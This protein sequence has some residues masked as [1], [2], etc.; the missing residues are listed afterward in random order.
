VPTKIL[1]LF[2]LVPIILIVLVTELFQGSRVSHLRHLKRSVKITAN[3]FFYHF[4]GTTANVIINEVLKSLASTPRPHFFYTCNPDLTKINCSENG[5]YVEFNPEM[6]RSSNERYHN[7][8]ASPRKMYDSMKSFP[9]G[10]AQMAC[11]TATFIIIYIQ[12]RV[13]TTYSRLW[14]HWLQ[15]VV[16]CLAAFASLSRVTDHRHHPVDVFAG[17]VLGTATAIFTAVFVA[18]FPASLAS[19]G[20]GGEQ[21]EQQ[22]QQEQEV[23][24]TTDDKRDRYARQ[25]R[26]SKM[27]LLSS[28]TDFGFGS[29]EEGDKEL[30]EVNPA[31]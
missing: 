18:R 8:L 26:P 20:A 7:H 27:R 24:D 5:G 25:K 4:I 11:F 28:M 9:S 10:H 23:A 17:A 21:Q 30:A 6:C 13:G 31:C 29:V 1:I 14:K 12:L 2:I 15:L 19:P 3:V 22:E 16:F